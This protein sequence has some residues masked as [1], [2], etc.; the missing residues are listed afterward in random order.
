MAL[1]QI[2]TMIS[3]DKN[4]K[5]GA[6]LINSKTWYAAYSKTDLLYLEKRSFKNLKNLIIY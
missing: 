3:K 6:I 4:T 2:S 1:A 5:V